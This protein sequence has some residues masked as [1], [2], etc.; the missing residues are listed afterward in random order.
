MKNLLHANLLS[1]FLLI[2]QHASAQ[3]I[4]YSEPFN[5]SLGTCTAANGSSGNWIWT[6]SCSRSTLGGHTN[7]GSALFQGSGCQ[8][9]NS[10]ATVSGDL[11]TPTVALGALGGTLQFNY[12]LNNECGTGGST[13][14]YDVLS[15]GISTNNGVSYTTIMASSGSPAGLV[16]GSAWV[17]VSYNLSAFA[18]QNIKVAFNF[19][20]IDGVL[21]AYDGV[22]VDDVVIIGACSISVSAVSGGSTV[23]PILCSGN[24][25]TLTT[26][27]VSNFSW[28]TGANT[29]SIVVSP[30]VN[31][32]YSLTATS[33]SN[34]VASSAIS[35]SVNAS[36]PVLTVSA[37]TNNVC[38][39]STVALTA[40]GALTY[41]WTGGVSN[42]VA[43][44]PTVSSSY[45][46]TGGNTCGTSSSAIALTVQPSPT[47]TA[48]ISQPTVCTGNTVACI[49]S[50]AVSYTWSNLVPNGQPFFPS[51]TTVYTAIGASAFGCTAQAMVSL[52]VVNT[53]IL[54]PLATPSLICIGGSGTIAAQ[55]ATNYTWLPVNTFTGS[56]SGTI[57]ITP[58]STATYTLIKA[59]S[60]C[61]DT[62][63]ITVFVNQL[64][65]VFAIA[66]P[67]IVCV[68]STATLS[69]GGA[70]SYTWTP[71]SFNLI[72]A[73]VAVTP[74]GSTIY[75]CTGSDGTCV[76]TYTVMLATNPVPTIQ[77]QT[78]NSAICA[79]ASVT[80][81]AS[82]GLNYTWTP[83]PFTGSV[84][85]FSP[86]SPVSMNVVGNN[87][88]N[89]TS[90]N[91]VAV[92]VYP[93]PTVNAIPNRTLVCTN[94]PS[95]IT[96]TG[97]NTYS[98]NTGSLSNT[99]VVYPSATTVYTVT[100]TYTNSGCSTTKTVQVQTYVP[101]TG[102]NGPTAVC[103]GSS[104]TI[105]S[106]PANSYTWTLNGNL[107]SNQPSILIGPT[108]NTTYSLGTTSTSNNVSC[109][110]GNSITIQVNPL[111][112]ITA[113]STRTLI[114]KNYEFTT[115]NGGGGVS[116]NWLF[117]GAGNSVTVAP[118]AQTIYTVEGTDANG[119]VNTATIMIRVSACTGINTPSQAQ[120]RLQIYPNPNS[121]EFSVSSSVEIQFE[122]F[123]GL[124]RIIQLG[125][126]KAG[127][128]IQINLAGSANGVYLLRSL[129]HA[130]K[131]SLYKLI[132]QK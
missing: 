131:E 122:I 114:C 3:T 78:S 43:F 107:L 4:L 88:F 56:N 124:G 62:K 36:V 10:S 46:V 103:I 50:G 110:G 60:N 45:T 7:P 80:L 79:G 101:V 128:S 65:N 111:P 22:Y 70:S 16:N 41:T 68:G 105:S 33:V 92:I 13:C 28:S 115:L 20:S 35:V 66:Q 127:E 84:V 102:I 118:L 129:D 96:A 76:A 27:A 73:N 117:I 58:T 57:V 30:T 97:A 85:V 15:V 125:Q 77:A 83:G 72:G 67:T 40:S 82:G 87:T 112:V 61:V 130:G 29:S 75:T 5:A 64:P 95:T 14:F 54:A 89:C 48:T 51:A 17:A 9:G 63:T 23:S 19:N 104:I 55:G 109:V 121:G 11:L 8:F 126:I 2:L 91:N 98:W 39:N 90:Q 106:A 38:M 86:S 42:G 26:N 12:S 120:E 49:A 24:S 18:N 44:T 32:S 93:N 113:S 69:G 71:S 100:G 6:N 74:T 119:C 34:C 132:I 25:L 99:I 21:N 94:G 116:Y 81:T 59:N 52:T 108:V 31:T 1:F 37:T 123:D 53:P 47:V